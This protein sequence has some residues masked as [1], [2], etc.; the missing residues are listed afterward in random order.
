MHAFGIGTRTL[1]ILSLAW[2]VTLSYPP[3]T[4]AQTATP[5]APLYFAQT[6][7]TVQ[8]PFLTFFNTTGGVARHG[9][10]ITESFADPQSGLLVQYFQKSRMEWHP[11]NPDP[12]KVLLGLLGEQ[13]GKRQPPIPVSQIQSFNNP[14]C[15]YF[16]ETGHGTCHRFLDFWRD[17]GGLDQF[18]YPIGPILIENNRIVQYTQRVRLEWHP[19]R[20]EGQRVQLANLGEDYF[21]VSGLDPK[22]KNPVRQFSGPGQSPVIT[23]R[24]RAAMDDFVVGRGA[25]QIGF[26]QVTDQLGYPIS[27]AAVTMIVNF[28]TGPQTFQL[29]PT[30]ANGTSRA[31][32]IVGSN[33]TPGTVVA[34]EFQISAGGITTSTRTSFLVWY[35]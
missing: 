10:P 18:G 17:N 27:G 25:T 8:A 16:K 12:Y 13:L 30:G 23:L 33:V 21:N 20:P 24:A 31:S 9:Y 4:V 5:E 19:D 35:F 6:G 15:H 22:L 26:V 14:N 7:H 3:S 28:P 29:P 32:F 1:A 34:V 2:L 11:G